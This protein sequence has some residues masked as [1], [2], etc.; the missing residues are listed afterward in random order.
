MCVNDTQRTACAIANAY[1]EASSFL[2]HKDVSA[3]A[4]VGGATNMSRQLVH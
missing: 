3:G 1:N 4:V 2:C